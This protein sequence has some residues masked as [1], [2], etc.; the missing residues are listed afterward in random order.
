M[1]KCKALNK[2]VLRQCLKVEYVAVCWEWSEPSP[3]MTIK[4]YNTSS[5]QTGLLQQT[6]VVVYRQKMCVTRVVSSRLWQLHVCMALCSSPFQGPMSHSS[7]ISALR[8][9]SLSHML[10]LASRQSGS[11]Q[12]ILLADRG[13]CVETTCPRS[14]PG[15]S[16]ARSRTCNLRVTSLARYR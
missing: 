2:I 1:I 9:T 15:S 14:L 11:Y 5:L 3:A 4:A 10:P 12:I 8:Q 6:T 16:P 7:V 13:M